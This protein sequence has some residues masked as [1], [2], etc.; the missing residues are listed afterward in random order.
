MTLASF[1]LSH[2]CTVRFTRAGSV[3]A[4]CPA[5]QDGCLCS[6]LSPAL[7]TLADARKWLGY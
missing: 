7:S 2:G 6:E 5:S 4:A 3:F 1:I